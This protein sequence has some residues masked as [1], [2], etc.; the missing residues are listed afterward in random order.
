MYIVVPSS[1][2]YAAYKEV[3]FVSINLQRIRIKTHAKVFNDLNLVDHLLYFP[4]NLIEGLHNMY[5][6]PKHI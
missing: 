6:Y 4:S 2:S 5:I 3:R 1:Y